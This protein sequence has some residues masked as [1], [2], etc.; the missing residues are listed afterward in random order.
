MPMLAGAVILAAALPA[1]D[2]GIDA[3]WAGAAGRP[4][5]AWATDAFE[6]VPEVAAVALVVRPDRL[7]T[8]RALIAHSGWDGVRAVAATGPQRRDVVRAGLA[9]LPADLEWV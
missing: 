6:R 8:A 3:A 9:A 5:L 4:V 7:D 1:V 2:Q